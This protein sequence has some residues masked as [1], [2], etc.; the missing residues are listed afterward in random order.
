MKYFL[1]ALFSL[2]SLCA[3]SALDGRWDLTLTSTQATYPGW[4]EV[5][6]K[7]GKSA[8][9][10]QPRGGSVRPVADARIE[11][12]KLILTANPGNVM[13]L[14]LAAGSLTGTEKR[15]EALV[16]NVKGVR[17]PVLN[18]PAPS[19]WS[20]P[21]SLFNGR[22]LTGWEPTNTQ[23]NNWTVRDGILI[24]TKSGA[25]LRGTRKFDDFKLHIEVNVP[26]DGNSGIYLRGR[27]EMQLEYVPAGTEDAYHRMGAIYG[28]VPVAVDSPRKPGEWE[29]FDITL[30]GRRVTVVRNG[31]TVINNQEIAGITGGALD[32]NEGEPGVFYIQGDHNGLLQFR[33]ITVSVPR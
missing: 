21:E 17:A 22:D 18:R 25:N 12:A 23:N 31:V 33:N 13:E 27:Y 3:Q 29:S 28:M 24:N 9:R 4:L 19:A 5:V 2:S 26:E 11:G 7:D 16:A 8:V 1:A 15:G 10:F 20:T 6:T 14:T 32:S 30:V